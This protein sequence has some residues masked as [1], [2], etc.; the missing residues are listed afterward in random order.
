M[1]IF[2]KINDHGDTIVEVLMAT[3][4]AGAVLTSA[5]AV[6]TRSNRQTQNSFE[7]TD[8]SIILRE[9]A[10]LLR[11]T[12]NNNSGVSPWD[13]VPADVHTHTGTVPT[14]A[15]PD[16]ADGKSGFYIDLV[17]DKPEVKAG[18]VQRNSLYHVWIERDWTA[19]NTTGDFIVRACWQ[20]AGSLGFQQSG[21]VVR[22]VAP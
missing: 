1:K 21:L 17:A 16:I 4:I 8:A 6:G 20:G 10:E 9:Q 13:V 5:Y 3:V 11:L 14:G 15:C 7:H 12:S 22:L 19:G 18:S 2:K